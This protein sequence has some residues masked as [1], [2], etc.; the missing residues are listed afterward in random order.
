MRV[1][2]CPRCPYTP[3][4]LSGHYDPK[5]VLHLC[6]K[7]DSGQMASTDHY[8]RKIHRRQECAT[9]FNID[10]T[11]Q[12]IVARSVKDGLASSGTTPG[13]RPSVPESAPTVSGFVERTTVDFYLAIRLPNSCGDDPAEISALR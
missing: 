8:S 9:V 6:V 2:L 10:A 12:P 13:E 4:D 11:A 1:K 7:C 3:R 5:A